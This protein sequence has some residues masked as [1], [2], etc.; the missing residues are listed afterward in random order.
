M[1]TEAHEQS[2]AF[3]F[4]KPVAWYEWSKG[5]KRVGRGCQMSV[6]EFLIDFA[7]AELFLL[8]LELALGILKGNRLLALNEIL[9]VFP[10]AYVFWEWLRWCW[11]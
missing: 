3:L 7:A 5:V 8:C 6:F 9:F 4:K 10:Q 1:S 11:C 2:W